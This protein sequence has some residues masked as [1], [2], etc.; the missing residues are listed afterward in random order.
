MELLGVNQ[1]Y[2]RKKINRY[3][4]NDED[5]I[6]H[7]W[8][9]TCHEEEKDLKPIRERCQ[10]YDFELIPLTELQDNGVPDTQ[11]DIFN[12]FWLRCW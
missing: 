6:K 2:I 3:Y 5:V 12:E 9:I 11:S 8:L 1:K 10:L 7:Y 4:V